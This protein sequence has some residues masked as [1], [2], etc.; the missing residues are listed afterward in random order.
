MMTTLVDNCTAREDFRLFPFGLIKLI[1]G[2][3][4][5]VASYKILPNQ[6]VLY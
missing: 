5:L 3:N 1:I 2:K 4:C 6:D